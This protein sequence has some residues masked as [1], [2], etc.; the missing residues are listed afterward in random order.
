MQVA[1]HSLIHSSAQRDVEHFM[2]L[3]HIPGCSYAIVKGGDIAV[4]GSTGMAVPEKTRIDDSTLFEC[5]SLTKAHFA[6]MALRLC[7]DGVFSLN[8]PVMKQCPMEPW[9]EDLRFMQVTPLHILSHTS[10]LPNW[11]ERPMPVLFTPGS[12]FSYS[13]EGYFL[14][15]TMLET[16]TGKPLNEWMDLTVFRPL[17]M[18]AFVLWNDAIAKRFSYGFD[19]SG[20]VCKIRDHRRTSG[21]APEPNAAW[22]LYANASSLARFLSWL[23]VHHAGLGKEMFDSMTS[24]HVCA[25]N[26]IQW[27]LGLGLCD[28]DTNVIWHWGDNAGFQSFMI[29]DTCT[30]DGIVIITNSSSGLKLCFHLIEHWSGFPAF[31]VFPPFLKTAE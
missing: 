11:S 2:D 3:C 30:K 6:A 24:A 13:G 17:G 4:C 27:G 26:G 22:S 15:Q 10:G 23:L 21:N 12:Q 18:D 29:G 1:P 20:Q 8:T 14:L 5:A 25:G 7:E 9:S 28:Q 19:T 31:S 16:I